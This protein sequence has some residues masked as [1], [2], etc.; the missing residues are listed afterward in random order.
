[1]VVCMRPLGLQGLIV[2]ICGIH[3]H[4]TLSYTYRIFDGCMYKEIILSG[5]KKKASRVPNPTK[6]WVMTTKYSGTSLNI[7][8][9]RVQRHSESPKP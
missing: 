8:G 3:G 6:Q 2:R 1:M 4:P 9:C 7:V 5:P